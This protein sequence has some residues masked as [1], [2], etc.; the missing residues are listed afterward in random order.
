[1]R[2]NLILITFLAPFVLASGAKAQSFPNIQLVGGGFNGPLSGPTQ[3][4]DL[5]LVN[6]LQA[7]NIFVTGGLPISSFASQSD[8]ANYATSN[9]LLTANQRVASAFGGGAGVDNNGFLTAPSYSV[10]GSNYNNVGGALSALNTAV[11]GIQNNGTTYLRSN[12]TGPGAQATGI[13]S[14]AFGSNAQA[15]NSGSIAIGTNSSSTG[16]NSTAIGTGASAT[17][18]S[19]A[20][21]AGTSAS[22]GGAAFGNNATATGTNSTAIGP[23]A[24]TTASNSVAIGNGSVANAANTVS[25]GSVGN[26]RRITNVAPGIAST[27]AANYG[28]L[29]SMSAGFQNQV[30]G[31][32]SQIGVNQIEARRGIAATAAI[33]SATTPS[34]PGKTTVSL[35]SGFYHGETGVGIAVAHR[36]KTA[37]PIIVYGGYANSGGENIGRVGTA[38]EF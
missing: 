34:A 33:T 12:S 14:L 23:N 26:E 18:S 31:L 29:Q 32:Q 24:S 17:G 10:Q 28:Q 9:N 6:R 37:I 4:T 15:T 30:T 38:L 13:N 27:D 16:V 1:M 11:T 25:V 8:L 19:V 7:G 3:P 22:N 5:V 21:G 36:L 20:V 2:A 35:T